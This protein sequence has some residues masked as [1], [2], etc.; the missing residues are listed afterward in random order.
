MYAQKHSKCGSTESV[1]SPASGNFVPSFIHE[2]PELWS[3]LETISQ[4]VVTSSS[5]TSVSALEM[6]NLVVSEQQSLKF[7]VWAAEFSAS[8]DLIKVER[9]AKIHRF[10]QSSDDRRHRSEDVKSHPDAAV[11][12]LQG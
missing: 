8:S 7:T 9:D 5:S 10:L 2:P 11:R 1:S 4:T 12:R 3:L 6:K